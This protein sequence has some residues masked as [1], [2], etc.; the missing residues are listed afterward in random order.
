MT[1]QP[2]IPILEVKPFVE[3]TMPQLR[4]EC[5]ILPL[6]ALFAP[7]VT[8]PIALP[9]RLHAY[10]VTLFTAGQGQHLVDFQ[11]YDYQA[12]ALLCV[13]QNQV[14]Q[15]HPN[16]NSNG[17][18]IAF[19]KDFLYQNAQDQA[20]LATSH[21]FNY[22]LQSP[23]IPLLENDYQRFGA[24]FSELKLEYEQTVGDPFRQ[25]IMRNLLRSI[26]LRAER[27]KANQAPSTTL[28]YYHDFIRFKDRVEDD[29][30]RTRN[31]VDYAQALGYSPKKLN[32]LSR[33]VLNKSAKA[34][35]DERV[36]LEIKR[37][38][39]HSDLSI[40]E[41]TEHIGFD[42]PTNLVKFFKRHTQQT[43]SMFRDGLTGY[44]ML[45]QPIGT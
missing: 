4:A 26:L 20:I 23:L 42:E 27:L 9:Q 2:S 18:V 21:I 38:L 41:I 24:L 3:Q 25:E 8:Y 13:A 17:L 19:S 31:V 6:Q 34:F 5:R 22:A 32:Q 37:L 39:A 7:T 12:P 33:L 35:I 44:A 45:A 40:K 30:N 29:F 36:L 10:M 16:A 28:A 1:H 15:W 43:P 14:H 11:A